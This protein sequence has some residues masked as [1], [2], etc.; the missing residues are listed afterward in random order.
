MGETKG[1]S[2]KG[3]GGNILLILTG[4]LMLA[5]IGMAVYIVPHLGGTFREHRA[6]SAELKAVK[7]ELKAAQDARDAKIEE[8]REMEV[9]D[10]KIDDLRSET[11]A[12]AAQLEEDIKAGRNDNKIC[13]LTID[14]GPYYHGKK[15]LAILDKY[16]V[17]ATFFLTTANGNKLPD[18]GE[19]SAASM[20]PE[21][22]RYGHTIGNHTYSH[23]YSQGGIYRSAKAFM[24]DVEKQEEFTAEATG[25]YRPKIVRFPGGRATAG[26]NLGDIEDALSASGY[27]WVDW[28]VDSGDSW[29]KDKASPELIMKQVK[30]A[31][32]D[33]KIMVVLCHEW[34]K[35]TEKALPEMIEYLEGQGYIFLPMF[36]ESQTVYK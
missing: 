15:L 1:K 24:A 14:D 3:S 27:G 36:Y 26:K 2:R 5:V 13:Y 4:L 22:L 12:L 30:K 23:D 6:R 19:L 11:F 10:E 7:E 8:K 21:Y 35:D 33:Q 31:A 34:S 18:K 9:D 25:G 28:T 32:K 29:G 20:Y 17:K 16:D